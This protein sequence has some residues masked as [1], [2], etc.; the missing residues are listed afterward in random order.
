[1]GQSPAQLELL[2]FVSGVNNYP[3]WPIEFGQ[4]SGTFFSEGTCPAR[5]QN[6]TIIKH[7]IKSSNGVAGFL[8]EIILLDTEAGRQVK[9]A[10]MREIG[11]RSFWIKRYRK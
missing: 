4:D 5:Y 10:K 2:E 3:S 1:M 8:K 11:T 6:R 9:E 7:R